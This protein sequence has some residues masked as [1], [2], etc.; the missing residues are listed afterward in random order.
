MRKLC[1]LDNIKKAGYNL[2]L[3]DISYVVNRIGYEQNTEG[4]LDKN[5]CELHRLKT[6]KEIKDFI[7]LSFHVYSGV[8]RRIRSLT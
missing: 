1:L 6:K 5:Y 4:L 8:Q 2:I 7:L 3:C